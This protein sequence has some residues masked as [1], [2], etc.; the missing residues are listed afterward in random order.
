MVALFYV[1]SPFLLALAVSAARV[2]APE[3]L[4]TPSAHLAPD[5]SAWRV[6]WSSACVGETCAGL[7]AAIFNSLRIVVPALLATTVLGVIAG[8]ATSCHHRSAPAGLYALLAFA[9]FVPAQVL[10]YPT[11]LLTRS[12]GLFSSLP[13]A[14][15]VHT[16][17]GFPVV[18]F[19]FSAAFSS[20]PKEVINAARLD[21]VN[22]FSM[23]LNIAIPQSVVQIGSV[24][25]LQF[26]FLWNDFI[27][28]YTFGGEV[29]RP[30][31]VWLDLLSSTQ[32]GHVDYSVNV[33]AALISAAPAVAVYVFL[34]GITHRA[35]RTLRTRPLKAMP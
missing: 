11:I 18:T 33:A 20:I 15:L 1:V 2:P 23:L 14:V 17:W 6:A 16:I 9:V 35:D 25:L 13:G 30:L 5:V 24:I 31:S 28:G 22:L 8:F 19:L 26:T 4:G 32:Y 3:I 7:H 27:V 21:G 34:Y 10:I 29:N 12:L